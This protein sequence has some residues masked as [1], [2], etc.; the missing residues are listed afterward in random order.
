MRNKE[1]RK[2]RF[3]DNNLSI[4][5][6]LHLQQIALHTQLVNHASIPYVDPFAIELLHTE[7]RSE[8]SVMLETLETGVLA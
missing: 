2:H 8:M 7:V 4:R 3:R 1:C 5:R 6:R